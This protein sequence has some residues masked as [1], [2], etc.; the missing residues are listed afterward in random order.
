MFNEIGITAAM[1]RAISF[2]PQSDSAY[3]RLQR[4]KNGERFFTALKMHESITV[5]S[6][7]VRSSVKNG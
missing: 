3:A 6:N 5:I 1:T 7:E 2:S 4:M